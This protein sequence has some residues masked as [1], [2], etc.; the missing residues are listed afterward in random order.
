M[1]FLTRDDK[2]AQRQRALVQKQL[3]EEQMHEKSRQR[4]EERHRS[5]VEMQQER[6]QLGLPAEDARDVLAARARRADVRQMRINYEEPQNGGPFDGGPQNGGPFHSPKHGG[7]P[8]EAPRGSALSDM[9]GP[10]RS[11][12]DSKREREL[13]HRR[14]LDQQVFE[15][16]RQKQ[17][18]QDTHREEDRRTTEREAHAES[19]FQPPQN[20]HPNRR[21]DP[22]Q[23]YQPAPQQQQQPQQQQPAYA[24]PS[25]GR[26][27][28]N[29]SYFPPV[30]QQQQQQQQHGSD[31]SRAQPDRRQQYLSPSHG[32]RDPNQAYAQQQQYGGGGGRA[33]HEGAYDGGGRASNGSGRALNDGGRAYDDGGR[34]PHD[35]G[36][37]YNDGGRAYDN[38]GQAYD[39]GGRAGNDGGQAYNDGGRAYDGGRQPADE[40]LG[41]L[42]AENQ[43]KVRQGLVIASFDEARGADQGKV[44]QGLVISGPDEA[45]GGDEDINVMYHKL[46]AEQQ[47]IKAEL[48]ALQT[49]KAAQRSRKLDD[50]AG[51]D[52]RRTQSQQS[53]GPRSRRLPPRSA[54]APSDDQQV[55][56]EIAAPPRRR[57]PPRL[58]EAD[59]RDDAD[60]PAKNRWGGL[61]E[62][63]KPT[64]P[65]KKPEGYGFGR[66]KP[67]VVRKPRPHKAQAQLQRRE[68]QRRGE[69]A[70]R[71]DDQ[72]RG[73]G[74]QRDDAKPEHRAKASKKPRE[75]KYRDAAP[76]SDDGEPE[77]TGG[78]GNPLRPNPL[79]PGGSPLRPGGAPASPVLPAARRLENADSHSTPKHSAL[80]SSPKLAPNGLPPLSRELPGASQ[81]RTG[82]GGGP[83]PPA[84]R[85]PSDRRN[86]DRRNADHR[87]ADHRLDGAEPELACSTKWWP[88]DKEHTDDMV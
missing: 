58:A 67:T 59:L 35:G 79:R 57:R 69:G 41:R 72:R 47:D 54:T 73:D 6:Y 3:L 62:G 82:R 68:E 33:P 43:G 37:G 88:L 29:Q 39:G 17:L 66:S 75:S 5:E 85:M 42:P 18:L 71:D 80:V 12:R 87:T 25:H 13:Q 44:R 16:N 26:R 52:N 60:A 36:Q 11:E 28:P 61:A 74:A 24:S 84:A 76:T 1:S 4:D 14:S 48:I 19:Y 9:I 77:I 78:G 50:D 38:G 46:L 22:N 10:S 40:R 65:Q 81:L 64:K 21:R 30:Q 86:A 20:Q 83:L 34:A 63:D 70:R 2:V 53:T 23:S 49:E 31:A 15:K 56:D 27:D 7:H 55:D 45:G 51:D 32:R 8:E